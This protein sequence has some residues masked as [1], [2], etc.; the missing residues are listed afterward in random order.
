LPAK[1]T[2]VLSIYIWDLSVLIDFFI[3]VVG[4]LAIQNLAISFFFCWA[5]AR[6]QICGR[7]ARGAEMGAWAKGV[8]LG[9]RWPHEAGP[10]A[11]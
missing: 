5:T 11:R 7:E 2:I 4:I 10:H 9:G 1:T 3:K 6:D 8:P